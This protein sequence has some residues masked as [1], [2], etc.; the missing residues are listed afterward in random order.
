[1]RF[2]TWFGVLADKSYWM[3]QIQMLRKKKRRRRKEARKRRSD[4][5]GMKKQTAAI[6]TH[7]FLVNPI[8]LQTLFGPAPT[9]ELGLDPLSRAALPA[10]DL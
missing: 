5:K 1:M 4:T 9:C 8:F 10:D 7:V 6:F 3:Q 2:L